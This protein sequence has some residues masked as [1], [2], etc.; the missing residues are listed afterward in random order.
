MIISFFE[1]DFMFDST[2][3][4]VKSKTN[5][6]GNFFITNSSDQRLGRNKKE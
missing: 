4:F 3:F 6:H 1:V 5:T 2:L